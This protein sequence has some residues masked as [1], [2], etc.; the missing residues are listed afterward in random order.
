MV[1]FWSQHLGVRHL[2][3]TV[4]A[5]SCLYT[6]A[7][8][9]R[10]TALC[11]E[12]LGTLVVLHRTGSHQWQS[13]LGFPPSVCSQTEEA[14]IREVPRHLP[15]GRGRGGGGSGTGWARSQEVTSSMHL[16]E[17]S[18]EG[19][20]SD[21]QMHPPWEKGAQAGSLTTHLQ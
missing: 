6:T 18:I 8:S 11:S 20:G 2:E 13:R 4:P 14:E 17:V 7:P 10:W 21:A 9:L 3:N 5:R 15:A 12:H 1:A 19:H 16:L